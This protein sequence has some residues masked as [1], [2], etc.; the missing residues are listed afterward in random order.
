[1]LIL[2]ALMFSV[3]ADS[4]L[5][6]NEMNLC[7]ENTEIITLYKDFNYVIKDQYGTI[8]FDGQWE[9]IDENQSIK[10]IYESDGNI[11]EMQAEIIE[12]ILSRDESRIKITGLELLGDT[13]KADFCY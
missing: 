10:L 1:M 13:Y 3:F 4:V 11:M 5:M 6:S 2:Q 8:L 12:K 7:N 9:W